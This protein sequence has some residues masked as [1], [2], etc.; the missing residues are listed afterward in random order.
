MIVSRYLAGL[1]DE[2]RVAE[3]WKEA[4]EMVK[5]M[6]V[7]WFDLYL[8]DLQPPQTFI[9]IAEVRTNG[10][11]TIIMAVSGMM[12]EKISKQ[13]YDA[14]ADIAVDKQDAVT[15]LQIASLVLLAIASARKRGADI[16]ELL[17]RSIRFMK[18]HYPEFP[19]PQDAIA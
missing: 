13:S 1:A 16:G 15:P 10:Q 18:E 2:I 17:A 3:T 11:N 12:D 9:R 7:V 8:P 14:G 6:D 4:E 5:G 19:I